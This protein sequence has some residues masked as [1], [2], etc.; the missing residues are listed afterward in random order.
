M[1]N[2]QKEAQKT[3]EKMKRRVEEFQQRKTYTSSSPLLN[4]LSSP[5][6]KL[7]LTIIGIAAVLIISMIFYTKNDGNKID[8]KKNFRPAAY[9]S[10]SV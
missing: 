1:S 6:L 4:F 7:I 2:E 8:T 3:L 9:T 5:N 10:N